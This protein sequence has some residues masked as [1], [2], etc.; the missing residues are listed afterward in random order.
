ML[1]LTRRTGEAVRIGDG[2]EIRVLNIH[3]NQVRIAFEAPKAMPVNREE[4]AE[5]IWREL[6]PQT[7]YEPLIRWGWRCQPPLDSKP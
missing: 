7:P 4:V 1:I 5:R 2:I 6:H 3:G